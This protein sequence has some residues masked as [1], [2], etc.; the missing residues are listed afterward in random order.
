[1]PWCPK[2]KNEYREGITVCADCNVPLVEDFSTAIAA[3]KTL[4]FNTEHKDKIDA[5]IKY[6]EYSGI[7]SY[8]V[9]ADENDY[10][11]SLYVAEADYK[12]ASKLF[13]G[14]ALTE[15][16]KEIIGIVNEDILSDEENQDNNSI[17]IDDDN[18]ENI[19]KAS[20]TDS[21][22]E[23]DET[24]AD[25][26]LYADE[27]VASA[28]TTYVRKSDR[29]KDYRFSAYTCLLCGIA[30]II[31]VILNMID[32]IGLIPVV[33]SQLVLLCVFSAFVIGG[34]VMFFN[35]KTIQ[36]E[37]SYEE[38][39]E[40]KVIEWLNQNVN[41]NYLMSLKDESTSDEINY[42][43]YCE[44]IKVALSVAVPEASPEMLDSLIDDHLSKI[45]K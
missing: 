28:P 22:T 26:S 11:Y 18:Q 33:F 31:F 38:E 41:D 12:N 42:F 3:D 29:A 9:E 14:F 25:V 16:E 1:M 43:K 2:C 39:T 13:T 40:K 30:G 7:H 24:E 5:F 15:S 35:S 20:E 4:V 44:V 6:L 19:S 10:I 45:D 17:D 23:F 32:V 8:S 21:I 34:I 37:A 27:D 36:S